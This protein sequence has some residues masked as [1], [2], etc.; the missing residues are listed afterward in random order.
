MLNE[1][2]HL[3]YEG[4]VGIETDFVLASTPRSFASLRM[5]REPQVDERTSGWGWP[6][7]GN[8]SFAI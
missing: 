2:K 1:V 4:E 5:T 3:A 7:C 8:A 6:H